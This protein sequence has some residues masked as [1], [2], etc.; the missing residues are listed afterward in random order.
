M[1]KAEIT[2]IK[3]LKKPPFSTIGDPERLFKKREL[4]ELFELITDIAA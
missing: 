1:Q 2:S 3:A 4:S